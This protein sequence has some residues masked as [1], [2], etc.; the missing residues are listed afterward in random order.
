[1]PELTVVEFDEFFRE[2]HQGREPFDWQRRLLAYLI[3][4]RRWPEVI[5]AP[6]G[7]GKTAVIDVHIFANALR[8]G[9]PRRLVLAVNRRALV[10]SQY[11]YA[12]TLAAKLA[13]AEPGSVSERVRDS[14][15][16]GAN[17]RRVKVTSIRGGASDPLSSRDWRTD[18]VACQILCVTPDMVGSRLLF[19]GYG[20]SRLARPIEAGMLAFDTAI[21]VD[22]AHLSRQLVVTLRRI[23]ELCRDA[24]VGAPP[25]QVV[26]TSATQADARFAA[27]GVAAEDIAQPG[28]LRDR[29]TR[30]KPVRI[31]QTQTKLLVKTL[32]ERVVAL[33]GE[34]QGIVG[35]LVN[36]VD[37]ALKVQSAISKRH[38][39]LVTRALVGP[40]R[41]FDRAEVLRDLG[42]ADS[43]EVPQVDIVIATQTLEVGVDLD[44]HGLVT[45]LAP[46][47]ALVQR[48]GRVNRLGA[49]RQGQIEVVAAEPI[50]DQMPYHGDDLKAGIDW[51]R[52]LP[53]ET[54]LAPWNLRDAQPP[55]SKPERPI[56]QRLEY[57]DADYFR[58][59][60][61]SLHADVNGADL[62]L[63]LRD[64]LD[65]SPDSG[66]VVRGGLPDD[67][68]AAQ[69]LIDLMPVEPDEVIPCPLSRLKTAL[70]SWPDFRAFQLGPDGATRLASSAD[71]KPGDSVVVPPTA[72]IFRQGVIVDRD[73]DDQPVADVWVRAGGGEANARLFVTVE[74]SN[75]S[76]GSEASRA[77]V[78]QL[79]EA[80]S[81]EDSAD[82]E[83]LVASALSLLGTDISREQLHDS[84]IDLVFFEG[85]GGDDRCSIVMKP[86]W[87]ALSG[88]QREAVSAG[89]EFVELDDH[90]RAVAERVQSLATS[91]GLPEATT[92]DLRLAGFL[93]DEGKRDVRFQA[94]LRLGS[95]KARALHAKDPSLLLAKSGFRS[96]ERERA[97][98]AR[99]GLN[100]WRHEQ[101]SAAHSWAET[102]EGR[103]RELVTRLVGTSHGHGRC[104][105][106]HD[107]AQVLPETNHDSRLR[108][109]A[110][111][112]Y[113][114]GLWEEIVAATDLRYGI[115]GAA[116]LEALLRAA[117]IQVSQEGC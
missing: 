100:G 105:F 41:P 38:P 117:D 76:E 99:E 24:P 11:D 8:F 57:W 81:A 25:V 73:P 26:A 43:I 91:L 66:V 14:L 70:D 64:R 115:W 92:Q 13:S 114:L 52:E 110:D 56:F 93:H 35:C 106:R 82:R 32:A 102:P 18:P 109:A 31:I 2:I 77:A 65:E 4:N 53:E 22:E 55:P 84:L 1:M 98:R 40:M 71:L 103:D 3:E 48:A 112:L 108:A 19:R 104:S 68:G 15:P 28:V 87:T 46:A 86:R 75:E 50:A 85:T 6:T 69:R 111:E 23:R 17:P 59:S 45:E 29:L 54:G 20:V 74:A 60:S 116:Y 58:H 49:R 5:D 89:R 83:E 62:G 72:P 63:W 51:L 80:E 21:V 16:G 90:Q 107:A 47:S 39:E 33:Q 95:R 42:L 88:M 79:R 44:L 101:R 27:V 34:T 97:F 36:R 12:T 30:P 94:L 7:S 9:A 78:D 61:T 96:V 113:G 37:T 10:D 67:D